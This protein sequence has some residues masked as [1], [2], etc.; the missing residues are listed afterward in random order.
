M[1]TQRGASLLPQLLSAS[2]KVSFSLFLTFLFF[3][4]PVRAKPQVPAAVT[5][6]LMPTGSDSFPSWAHFP[7]TLPVLPETISKIN[8]LH[9]HSSL[10]S[11]P[12]KTLLR[13]TL[14]S[15]SPY[16]TCPV[17]LRVDIGVWRPVNLSKL[18]PLTLTPGTFR[19]QVEM[20]HQFSPEQG[21]TLRT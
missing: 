5:S 14:L 2:C 6:S 13:W 10:S 4:V 7:T 15:I 16:S 1:L 8:F 12:R 17:S 9:L 20:V 3:R 21:P 11:A 18:L 19:K